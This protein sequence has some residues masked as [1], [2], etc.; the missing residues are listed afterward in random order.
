MVAQAQTTSV[1]E[2]QRLQ[3]EA[4]ALIE[5]GQEVRNRLTQ[6]GLATIQLLQTF[7]GAGDVG[8]HHT[9]PAQSTATATAAA[10]KTRKPYTKRQATSAPAAKEAKT[11]GAKPETKGSGEY[12]GL[13]EVIWGIL[14]RPENVDGLMLADLVNVIKKEGK[15]KT[16]SSDIK[17]MVYQTLYKMRGTDSVV[18]DPE[19]K[20]FYIP[21]GATLS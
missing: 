17:N 3:A 4:L 21:E 2:L 14:D 6:N 19:S 7:G 18:R 13:K 12:M 9:Q 1:Q 10:P 16:T 5:Q 15:Y 20:K 8:I 11:A